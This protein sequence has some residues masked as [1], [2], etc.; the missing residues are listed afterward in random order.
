LVSMQSYQCWL[1]CS[2][3]QLKRF[4]CHIHIG[5][6]GR[7]KTSFIKIDISAAGSPHYQPGDHVRVFPRN[8]IP[9]EQLQEFV[10]HLSGDHVFDDYIYVSL[11]N[12]RTPTSELAISLPLVHKCL[13]QLISLQYFFEKVA[14]ILAPISNEALHELAELTSNDADRALLNGLTEIES[15]GELRWIDLFETTPSLSKKVSIEFLLSNMKIN[16]PRSYSISS[17]GETVGSELHLCVG[18]F[19]Y[20]VF[21]E[22]QKVGICSDFL[23]S[24]EEGDEVLFKL[25]SS[26]R[27]HYPPDRTAPLIMICTGTG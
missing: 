18:R 26:P 20:N 17:C 9:E 27:F 7:R 2:C 8:V 14:A 25:E 24:V 11:E 23:T 4:F 22:E 3:P 6:N 12:E 21:G 19:L 16:H 15:K 1:T 10:H 13:S 5:S